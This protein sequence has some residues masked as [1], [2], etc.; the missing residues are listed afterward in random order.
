MNE[1]GA[2]TL[3]FSTKCSSNVY[4][5]SKFSPQYWPFSDMCNLRLILTVIRLVTNLAIRNG[6]LI[7]YP[8]KT[9]R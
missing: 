7:I 1:A 9:R 2:A 3:D 6:V 8:Q 4:S 5:P